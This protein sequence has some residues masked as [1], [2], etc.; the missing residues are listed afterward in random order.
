MFAAIP[1]AVEQVT[2]RV[3]T[4]IGSSSTKYAFEDNTWLMKRGLKNKS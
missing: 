1:K 2:E 4:N 3:S